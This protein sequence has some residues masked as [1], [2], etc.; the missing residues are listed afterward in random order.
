MCHDVIQ[1][2]KQ[3]EILVNLE[4]MTD[5]LD[6]EKKDPTSVTDLAEENAAQWV[7]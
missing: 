6:Q 7:E 3:K 4:H 1:P 5:E 2:L